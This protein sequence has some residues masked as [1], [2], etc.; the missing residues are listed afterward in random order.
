[1]AFNLDN[2]EDVA[3]RVARFQQ[4]YPMGRIYVKVLDFDKERGSILVEAQVF[5]TDT[6]EYP[7]ATD[8][9]MEWVKKSSVS[10][11]WWVENAATSAIGRAIA[12]VIPTE[13][14]A[15]RESM[16]VVNEHQK[17]A[18]PP[19]ERDPWSVDQAIDEVREQIGAEVLAESPI[20][21][22]G[23][24]TLREGSK[25]V[26]GVDKPYRGFVCT[27]TD[28]KNQCPAQWMVLDQFSKEW[29]FR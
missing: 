21:L 2:Y 24:M 19:V 11:K 27:E 12:S 15:T 26:D 23:H 29:S 13:V 7:A 17:K 10:E 16:A 18:T 3:S 9:A 6:E 25:M 5:R 1:M 4:M 14:K 8:I 20:C 28:R 22:H